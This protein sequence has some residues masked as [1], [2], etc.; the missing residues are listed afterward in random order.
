MLDH[1]G[2]RDNISIHIQCTKSR[3]WF[4]SNEDV[5]QVCITFM[6]LANMFQKYN[7]AM[8][9]AI[10]SQVITLA[11]MFRLQ[12][13]VW[14]YG[15]KNKTCKQ[16]HL[17]LDGEGQ[18]YIMVHRVRLGLHSTVFPKSKPQ[19]REFGGNWTINFQNGST[20]ELKYTT[21]GQ[22][23]SKA[24]HLLSLWSGFYYLSGILQTAFATFFLQMNFLPYFTQCG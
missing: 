4:W 1:N 5:T 9:M 8:M 2:N 11:R 7:D 22:M 13:M 10:H 17:F 15:W 3:V 19:S 18:S 16:F 20:V 21:L 24:W 12:K 6:P 14:N 23:C